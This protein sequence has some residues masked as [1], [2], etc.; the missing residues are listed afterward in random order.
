VGEPVELAFREVGAGPPVV[1][2]HGLLGSSRNWQAIG[3]EL[4]R[5]YRVILPDLR[6]HGA[7][8]RS[9]AMTYPAMAADLVA[10]L[11]R[12]GLAEAAVVG[13]SMGGKAAIT[14]ALTRPERVSRLVVVDIAPVD[15]GGRG[16]L[17]YIRALQA[18]DLA[19]LRRRAEADA[20]LAPAVPDP[21]V[22]AFLLQNLG[23]EGD[24]PRWQP[25]LESLSRSMAT[26][27]GF[28]AWLAGRRF[29]GPTLLIR[30][31]LSSYVT[32]DGVA[33]CRAHC[34]GARLM[35]VRGAGHW[36]HADAPAIVV[37]ALERFL[38]G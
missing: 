14:L 18:L 12:L 38:A 10:L 37:G 4:G 21:A 23:F 13:H 3:K 28:P 32:A 24:R 31:E 2:L 22:R 20:A 35:T 25:D 16:F 6:N 29:A 8:P 11:D 36:V 26:I 1:I 5:R 17:D 33:A 7:S 9:P 30:G 34:P 19:L 27:T 15:Y